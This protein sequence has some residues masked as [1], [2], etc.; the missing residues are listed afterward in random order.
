MYK[1]C[2]KKFKEPLEKDSYISKKEGI[3]P[4]FFDPKIFSENAKLVISKLEKYLSDTSIKGLSLTEPF[5]LLKKA[6]SFMV[7][8][9][10][11]DYSFDKEKF[12]EI[13]DLYLSTGIQVHSPGYMGRQFSSV[14]PLAG[15]FDLIN[16]IVNQPSSFYEAGQLPSVVDHIMA[17]EFNK[18]IGWPKDQFTMVTTS[19]GSL[20]NLT[21]ILAARNDKLP[22]VWSSGLFKLNGSSIPAIAVSD[23][24]HYSVSRAAG[25]LGIGSEQIVKLP[26]NQSKQIC[27]EKVLPTIEAAERR[28]LKVFCMVGSAGNS[29]VGA[30][31]NISELA[32]IA[33]EKNIWLHIDG[34]HGGSFII[35]DSLRYK[36]K[37]IEKV[38][39]FSFDAHKMMFVPAMCSLLF[40]KNKEKAYGAFK[41]EASYVFDKESDIYNEFD[42]A[43]K[44]FECTKRPLIMNLW[45]TWTLYGRTLFANKMEY[46]CELANKAYQILKEESDFVTLH[47]PEANILC[48]RYEPVNLPKKQL[49][50]FQIKIRN[51]VKKRGNFFISK[52][53][54]D[55]VAALRVVFM[56]HIITPEHF[57]MLLR[58]I[59][60]VGQE[61]LERI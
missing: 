61:L 35:S 57:K 1:L 10:S 13:I 54:I 52:V 32:N 40:Y 34:A 16:S 41:Q 43:E 37:G 49:C 17:D 12:S 11:S 28:G 15:L 3:D 4:K 29:S 38:D 55:D 50:S 59:R 60:T 5:L 9:E 21:A 26:T 46:L 47:K 25:I 58:E 30:F 18:F 14:I 39:S 6:K 45:V 44:N 53:D 23:A 2:D 36:L 24:V 33:R 7:E 22:N 27:I 42:S 31:D 51:Q 48:F 19:G 56:N 8:K 20:A